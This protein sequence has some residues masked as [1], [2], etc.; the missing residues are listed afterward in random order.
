MSAYVFWIPYF[1]SFERKAQQ[2]L[3]IKCI[4]NICTIMFVI[5]SAIKILSNSKVPPGSLLEV[6]IGRWSKLSKINKVEISFILSIYPIMFKWLFS[7]I[8]N[9]ETYVTRD[10]G[11]QY[12]SKIWNECIWVIVN[13]LAPCHSKPPTTN[14][15]YLVYPNLH[16][17]NQ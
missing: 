12:K 17:S 15:G 1:N 6:F 7:I 16:F 2:T 14:R 4:A 13:D 5:I 10:F 9:W 3:C 8:I 11:I